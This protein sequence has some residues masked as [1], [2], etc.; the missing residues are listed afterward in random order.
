MKLTILSIVV[1]LFAA[2]DKQQKTTDVPDSEPATK[3]EAVATVT[4]GGEKKAC[5]SDHPSPE[6]VEA[7]EDSIYQIESTWKD[8]T[9]AER[10]LKSLGGRVQVITMGYSTCKF[11]CPRLLADMRLI[12]E[13]LAEDVRKNIGFTFDVGL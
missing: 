6:A 9:G 4:T 7:S 1:C 12:E 13:G 2:C 5:C 8:D 11:A 10:Q 3:T